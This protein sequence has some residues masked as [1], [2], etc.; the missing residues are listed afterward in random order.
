MT[1]EAELSGHN[2]CEEDQFDVHFT[3]LSATL[4]ICPYILPPMDFSDAFP[5]ELNGS[6]TYRCHS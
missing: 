3:E 4:L 2:G 5:C 6:R 1:E